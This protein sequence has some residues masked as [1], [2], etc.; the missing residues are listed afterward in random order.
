MGRVEVEFAPRN[1]FGVLDHRV[2]LPG[3]ASVENP[4]RVIRDGDGAAD[5]VFTLRRLD[6]VGEEEFEADAA[7]VAADLEALKRLLEADE[8]G[9]PA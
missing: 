2:T 8:G 5:V 6:G 3:G 7:A 9:A 4:L 1:R